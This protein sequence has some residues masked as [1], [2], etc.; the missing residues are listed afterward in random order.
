MEKIYYITNQNNQ[1][2]FAN[3]IPL[4]L[5]ATHFLKDSKLEQ[6]LQICDCLIFTSK[7][8]ILALENANKN[9]LKIPSYVLS[10]ASAKALQKLGITPFFIGKSGYGEGFCD[11]LQK[12]L[13]HKNPLF[14]RAKEVAS[15]IK[16][17][18]KNYGISLQ[19][20][21]LYETCII[22]LD[23]F[24]KSKLKPAKNSVI[25]FS[26]PSYCKAFLQNF[27]WDFSYQCVCIGTT[28][29]EFA[30]ANLG[31]MAKI[32]LSP[33]PNIKDSIAFAK[34]LIN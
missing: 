16:E 8:A 20:S 18:L 4:E 25:F 26:A 13:I 2:S 21:I 22:K 17:S 12:N 29:L 10:S 32:Y 19:E 9:A 33:Q 30:K 34:T 7:N 1:Q 31:D 6:K 3:A 11:E 14:I 28:T 5:V 23:N 24:Q 27:E 15:K